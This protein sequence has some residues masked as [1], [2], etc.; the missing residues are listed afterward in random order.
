MFINLTEE[1]VEGDDF[2]KWLVNM[3]ALK[4]SIEVNITI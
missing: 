4:I 3:D 1:G 2:P